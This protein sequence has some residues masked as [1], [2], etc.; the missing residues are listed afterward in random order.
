MSTTATAT[1]GPATGIAAVP[2]AVWE[3]NEAR[4]ATTMTD[5]SG[6]GRHGVIGDDVITKAWTGDGRGYRWTH[7]SPTAPPAKPERLVTVPDHPS[8]DPGAGIYSVS[9]RFQTTRKFGNYLQKGQAQTPGGQMKVQGPKG[10][11]GCL[12]KGSKGRSAT[13]SI[14]PLN[15]G[16]WHVVTCR[17]DSQGVTMY[18]DGE[19]RN[20]N[21]RDPGFIDN[22]FPFTIGGKPKCDQVKVTCDY[23]VGKMDWVR[24]DAG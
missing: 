2:A 20:R 16:E 12:F 19:F 9:F 21:R 14:T 13:S 10:R 5:A 23:F 7:T 17:K 18:V 1:S 8:L 6:N 3:M 4:D 15:D 11:V 24:I 22:N